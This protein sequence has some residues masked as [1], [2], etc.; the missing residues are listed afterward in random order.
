MRNFVVRGWVLVALGLFLVLFMGAIAWTIAPIMLD[1][2]VEIDG[3]TFTGTAAEAETFLSLFGLVI[4]FGALCVAN[5]V[6]MIATRSQS[7]GFTF[8]TL[9][10]A[11]LLYALATAI[12]R[13][14][15]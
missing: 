9:A 6:Y 15:I 4:L 8:A 11:A 13:G 1:P 12:R 5:G 3:S 10:L 14:L 2:G 7:R